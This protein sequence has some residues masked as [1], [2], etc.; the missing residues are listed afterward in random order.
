[1]LK[2]ED[3][4]GTLTKTPAPAGKR[5]LFFCIPSGRASDMIAQMGTLPRRTTFL[6]NSAWIDAEV[7][8]EYPEIS[9]GLIL[10]APLLPEVKFRGLMLQVYEDSIGQKAS[11][12]ELLGI[13]AAKFVGEIVSKKPESRSE[14]KAALE[15][16]ET[17]FGVSVQLDFKRSHE[18][19]AVRILTY[20]NQSF[21]VLK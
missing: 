15:Q 19:Q 7:L 6:G 4:L 5:A 20:K 12:W 14:F 21:Q 8:Q 13:D 11:L 3:S 10:A 1:M 16:T 17:F 2:K 18:N 9:D